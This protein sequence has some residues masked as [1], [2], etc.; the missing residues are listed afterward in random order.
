MSY[1]QI[2]EPL[3]LQ[4]DAEGRLLVPVLSQFNN[5]LLETV[6]FLNG[7]FVGMN[8][9][10]AMKRAPAARTAEVVNVVSEMP[11]NVLEP[12]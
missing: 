1:G 12:G 11:C 5:W 4:V 6:R 9:P 7:Y 8:A 2:G 3:E 10:F